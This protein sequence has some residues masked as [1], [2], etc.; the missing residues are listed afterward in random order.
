M[1]E[2]ERLARLEERVTN[3][4]ETTNEYRKNLCCK[5]DRIMDTLTN[6]PCKER[7]G[8]YESMNKQVGWVWKAVGALAIALVVGFFKHILGS[9]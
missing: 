6:L 8:W 9:K 2:D 4:M 7:K 3:W 5:I 1:S